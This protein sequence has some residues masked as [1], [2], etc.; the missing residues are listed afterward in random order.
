MGV[1]VKPPKYFRR[2]ILIARYVAPFFEV[3]IIIIIIK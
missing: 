1:E 2:L 3:F